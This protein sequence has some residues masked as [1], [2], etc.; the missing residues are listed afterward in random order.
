M[1]PVLPTKLLK[2]PTL[3]RLMTGI[4]LIILPGVGHKPEY[5]AT[6]TVVDA[7]F[8]VAK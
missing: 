2:Q 6:Q 4:A 8:K 1:E 5:V 3:V 7:I